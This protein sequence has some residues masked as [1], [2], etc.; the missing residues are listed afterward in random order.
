MNPREFYV[1]LPIHLQE[2][3]SQLLQFL[4]T[5]FGKGQTNGPEFFY[6][7]KYALRLC[8]QEKRMCAC[9]RIYSMMSMHEEAV[10]LA[11][12]VNLIPH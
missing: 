10:A 11:L 9:V 7:L 1:L 12:K 2:D 6:D 4:D 8:L 3:E 5:K